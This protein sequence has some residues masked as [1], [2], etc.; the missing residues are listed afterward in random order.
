M[1]PTSVIPNALVSVSSATTT[2]VVPA[3][4]GKKIRVWQFELQNKHATTDMD[5]TFKSAT[6]AIDA[7]FTVYAKG[8]YGRSASDVA[9]FTTASGEALNIT[10]SAAGTLVGRVGYTID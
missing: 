6:T 9:Y 7:A 8:N 4:P 10:T 1:P 2:E 5:V 3:Q